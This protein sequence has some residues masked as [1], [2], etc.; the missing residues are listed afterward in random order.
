VIELGPDRS[1]IRYLRRLPNRGE[2]IRDSSG[3]SW[4]VSDV[5]NDSRWPRR[6]VLRAESRARRSSGPAVPRC[7]RREAARPL[8]VTPVLLQ[9]KLP[10][11]ARLLRPVSTIADPCGHQPFLAVAL[12]PLRPAAFFCAVVPPCFELPP[13]PDFL[14]P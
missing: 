11:L 12:P 2:R 13:E 8:P 7:A 10:R 5:E 1:E 3:R 4:F 9:K 14:P 6:D